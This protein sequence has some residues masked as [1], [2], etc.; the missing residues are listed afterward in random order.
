[1]LF[2][3]FCFGLAYVI[4]GIVKGVWIANTTTEQYWRV[5]CH[6]SRCTTGANAQVVASALNISVIVA[7]NTLMRLHREGRSTFKKISGDKM[8][9][10]YFHITPDGIA[11]I[12][13]HRSQ[14]TEAGLNPA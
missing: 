9:A 4:Y 7:F 11:T 14:L 2:I 5:L 8:E 3:V 1:M 6:L 10:W 13:E 12:N